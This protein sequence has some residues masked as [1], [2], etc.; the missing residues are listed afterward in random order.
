MQLPKQKPIFN[1]KEVQ[2]ILKSESKF[3]TDLLNILPISKARIQSDDEE[4]EEVLSDDDHNESND[5]NKMK[6]SKIKK[7]RAKSLVELQSRLQQI[8]TKKHLSYKERLLKKTIKTK[9]KKKGKQQQDH[10]NVKHKNEQ[11]KKEFKQEQNNVDNSTKPFKIDAVDPMNSNMAFS[12]FDFSGIGKTKT[13][14]AKLDPQK[15]LETL[16]KTKEEVKMLEQSG[17]IGKAVQI[18]QKVSWKN[19]FSKAEGVKVKD[20]EHLLAKTI[21]RKEQKKKQSKKKWEAREANVKKLKEDRQQKRQENIDKRKKAKK[22][23]K[24]KQAVKRG[25][26]IPGF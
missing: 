20:D 10:R 13:K 17:E 8:S 11:I 2:S 23:K 4:D 1:I 21:K 3:I 6:I 25:K 14:K 22:V 18:N 12:K 19:A 7:N 15:M 9:I 16:K 24:M 26:V 5:D